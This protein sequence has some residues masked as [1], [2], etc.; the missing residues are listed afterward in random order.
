MVVKNNNNLK[1]VYGRHLPSPFPGHFAKVDQL[2]CTVTLPLCACVWTCAFLSGCTC[3][4]YVCCS[5]YSC[6]EWQM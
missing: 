3:T 6:C 1:N 4:L 2:C 5:V